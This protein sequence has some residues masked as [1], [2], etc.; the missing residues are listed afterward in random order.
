MTIDKKIVFSR[1]EKRIEALKIK[2]PEYAD[3][4]VYVGFTGA[5]TALANRDVLTDGLPGNM[6]HLPGKVTIASCTMPNNVV[7][8]LTA[9]A[10]GTLLNKPE[11][12]EPATLVS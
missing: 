7:D 5:R 11:V 4:E 8:Q 9:E 3:A 2:C 10:L 12:F 6:M 1:D